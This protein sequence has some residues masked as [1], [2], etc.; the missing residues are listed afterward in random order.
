ML[1]VLEVVVREILVNSYYSFHFLLIAISKQVL[2]KKKKNYVAVKRLI[3]F[4]PISTIFFMLDYIIFFLL[5]VG[6]LF[7]TL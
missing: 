7:L 2:V 4:T 6:F 3:Y 5:L 1:E